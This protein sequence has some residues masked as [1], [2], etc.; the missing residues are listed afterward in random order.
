MNLFLQHIV[1]IAVTEATVLILLEV[2]MV[3][4]V[5]IAVIEAIV[6]ILLE[7]IV[8]MALEATVRIHLPVILQQ[9]K[10]D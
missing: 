7:V 2:D 3:I 9:Q 4:T 5:A 6:L 1:H 8:H 10:V